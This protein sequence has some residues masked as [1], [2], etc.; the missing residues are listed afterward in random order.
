MLNA[1]VSIWREVTGFEKALPVSRTSRK[2]INKKAAP[3]PEG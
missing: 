1:A 3:Q 2:R